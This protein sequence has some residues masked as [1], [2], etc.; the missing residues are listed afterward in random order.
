MESIEESRTRSQ[1]A[2][3]AGQHII[4]ERYGAQPETDMDLRA[5]AVLKECERAAICKTEYMDTTVLHANSQRFPTVV[6][7]SMLEEELDALLREQIM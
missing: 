7:R 1:H 2:T 3:K 6:L 4:W 5:R